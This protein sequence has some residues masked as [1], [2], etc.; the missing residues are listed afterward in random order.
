MRMSHPPTVP[1]TNLCGFTGSSGGPS[2]SKQRNSVRR[3]VPVLHVSISTQTRNRQ[4]STQRRLGTT[5]L[6]ERSGVETSGSV[7]CVSE[8]T[9]G[10]TSRHQSR[11]DCDRLWNLCSPSGSV[12][13]VGTFF[14][15]RYSVA[16]HP[17]SSSTESRSWFSTYCIGDSLPSR[18]VCESTPLSVDADDSVVQLPNSALIKLVVLPVALSNARASLSGLSC[19]RPR[20]HA[21]TRAQSNDKHYAQRN[22]LSPS[23]YTSSW[24]IH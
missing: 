12:H 13:R 17:P 22:S 5:T 7:W 16:K 21:Y 1:F 18:T 11:T 19:T 15:Y 2:T 24:M 9:Q 4:S 8:S 23:Y 20:P 14:K 6:E 10:R 3:Q